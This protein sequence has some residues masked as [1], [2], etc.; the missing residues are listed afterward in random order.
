MHPS[1]TLRKELLH[2]FAD[3][4]RAR[5]VEEPFGLLVHEPDR[6]FVIHLEDR[7]RGHFK[8]FTKGCVH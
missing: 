7:I 5:A 8:E 3:Q 6:P 2:T 1:V 4:L